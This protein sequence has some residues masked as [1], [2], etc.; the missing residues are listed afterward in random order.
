MSL[1]SVVRDVCAAVGVLMPNAVLSNIAANRTMQEMLALANEM[2]QRI[3]F[4]TRDWTRLKSY[5]VYAGNGV[6]TSFPLPSDYKRMLLTGN[7]WLGET[8]TGVVAGASQAPLRFI[9]D[10]DEWMHRR[11]SET[12]AGGPGEWTLLGGNIVISPPIAD[13]AVAWFP[14]LQKNCIALDSG[15]YSDAFQQDADTFLLDERLLKLGMIWQWKSNKGNA[16]AE[17]MGTYQD[18]LNSIAG[19]DSPAPIMIGY[20]PIS[21]YARVAPPT[22]AL[23]VPGTGP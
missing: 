23:F 20:A 9:P 13:G 7:V 4:D 3:A 21:T 11:A 19:R 15:G 2:A 16:Y 18:A 1:L 14:F 22:Q 8:S 12:V 17:D 10:T 5:A 6:D